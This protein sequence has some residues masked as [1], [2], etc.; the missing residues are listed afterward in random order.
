MTPEE[1]NLLRSLNQNQRD[2]MFSLGQLEYESI[3]L[4]LRKDNL[5]ENIEQL[6]QESKNLGKTLTEKYGSGDINLETGEITTV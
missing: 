1:L 2:L 6:E 3:L 5:K 4:N